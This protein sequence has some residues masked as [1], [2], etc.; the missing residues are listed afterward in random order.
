MATL[1]VQGTT[2]DAGKSTLVTALCRWLIRQ[3]V[4]VVPFKPQNMALNSAVTADGGEIGRAQAVQAQACFLEPHTDMNPVL[5][6]PNSDTGAQVII[7]GRAVTTM[8]AVAYHGYKEIA[9]QAVLESHRRLGESYPVIM[10]EGAGS[11]AEINLRANDIA[12]MG[13]AEAVDCPVLLIA[14]INRGG[15]F[16]HLVGTLELLSPSEQARVKGFIINRFR[17]DIAL[18]QPGLDWL[19]ARTGKPVVGVLPYVMD[20][21]LEAE[22]GLDQRQTDKVEQ[23]LNVVVPVLPR[24]SNHTDFDPLRLHPQVNLQFIGPGQAIPPADLIILP[25]SKSVRSDLKY[26]RANGWDTAIDRHL[27]YGGKLMGICGGLQMLGEYLH[28]PLGLEGAAGSS[29]GLGLLAMSTVL[30]TEKQL[31]NVRGHLTL[32]DAEV[33]G[34]EIHAGVTT[35]TALEQAAVRLDDGRCDGAQSTDG[36]ILGTYLHGLFESPAACSALLRWAGLENVQSVDYHALRE[37]DIE[38]LA[39]LVEKH[40]DGR[41]LRE[42]CGLE[43]S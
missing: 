22:D 15:V 39:D 34:Y 4:S 23:V 13:F 14:D 30:E 11:P 16:A 19:E 42:L 36:Q 12:N 43:A 37:R 1:M 33:S 3:G 9:M 5:L 27:R 7:H 21:H 28:D 8:N 20:L 41:L 38:R 31:R 26:L 24:I 18:L 29:P 35:G 17:G 25:G 40:L 10:V 32:E 2:S 6:K